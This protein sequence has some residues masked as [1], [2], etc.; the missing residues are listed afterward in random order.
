MGRFEMGKEKGE[1]IL[2]YN[3]FLGHLNRATCIL[4][5]ATLAVV[6]CGCFYKHGQN[7]SYGSGL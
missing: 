6:H 3:N 5:Q 1:M 2:L 4:Q 7:Y